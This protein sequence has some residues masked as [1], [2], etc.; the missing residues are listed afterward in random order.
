MISSFFSRTKPINYVVLVVFTV[1][2]YLLAT[3]LFADVTKSIIA[4]LPK[5]AALAALLLTIFS[6]NPILVR[7]K[8]AELNSL[9]MLFFVLFLAAFLP[10]LRFDALIISNFLVVLSLNQVL[11]LRDEKRTKYKIFEAALLVMIAS[12]FNEWALAFLVPLY[13]GIYA[14][15]PGQLRHWFM[16]VAAFVA[17]ALLVMAYGS[18]NHGL[19]WISERFLFQFNDKYGLSQYYGLAA[20]ALFALVVFAIVMVKLGNR[21]IGRIVS[22]RIVATYLFVGLAVALIS[23]EHAMYAICYSFIATAIFLSNYL[24]TIQKKRFKEALLIIL[25]MIPIV[26]VGTYLFNSVSL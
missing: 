12:L 6:I 21:G 23:K 18:F 3:I 25:I 1:F 11:S 20:Y 10:L 8:L 7:N 16:P 15:C 9:T 26:L 24:E 19:S 2:L 22:L 14:Y 4:L 5:L 13:F 17:M